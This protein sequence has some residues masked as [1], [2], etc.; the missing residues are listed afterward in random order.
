MSK[1]R[2]VSPL[3][4]GTPVFI[5]SVTYYYTGRI[6]GLTKEEILLADAAW[7]ADTGRFGTA[8]KTG[9]L[10]EVE[11]FRDVV[12]VARGSVVD[13]TRWPHRLPRMQK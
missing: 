3:T 13:V 10:N 9:D 12:S 2:I 6:I 4:L 7:I 8:L 1:K 11:P 5:R